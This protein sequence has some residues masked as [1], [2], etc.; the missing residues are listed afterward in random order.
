[1]NG[2]GLVYTHKNAIVF[3]VT[4]VFSLQIILLMF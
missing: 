3:Y 4:S 2:H 1:M